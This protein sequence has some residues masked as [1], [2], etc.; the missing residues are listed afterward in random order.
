MSKEYSLETMGERSATSC[1]QWLI[2]IVLL[3][4][5]IATIV[6]AVV[7]LV[8]VNDNNNNK[9]V[10]MS[11]Q[12]TT[13]MTMTTETTTTTTTQGIG[14]GP[15]ATIAPSDTEKLNSYNQS[16]QFFL[17]SVNTSVDACDDFY[18]YACGRYNQP[19]SFNNMDF[20][21][22]RTMA[23]QLQSPMYTS[24]NTATSLQQVTWLFKQCQATLPN[25]SQLVA[26]GSIAL[27]A[28]RRFQAT[29]GL[30]F[31]MLN[32]N[33]VVN[34][35]MNSTT[36]ALALGAGTETLISAFI[37]TNWKQP[38]S[39]MPYQLY[40]D[41]NVLAYSKTYY[42]PN[43]WALT[44]P[45]Y[46]AEITNLLQT[47]ARL[48]NRQL[49][50]N[51]LNDDIN[52]IIALELALARNLSTDDATRR[53][54]LRSYNPYTLQQAQTA[55][56]FVHWPT[57]L[58]Q[59]TAQASPAVQSLVK[60]PNYQLIFN[61]VQQMTNLQIALNDS[62][63]Y[64][65]K[66]RHIVN[67]VN[68]RL[69]RDYGSFLP[70]S[71]FGNRIM[72]RSP[73][74]APRYIRLPEPIDPSSFAERDDA[75]DINCAVTTLDLQYANAR[76]FVDALL[77]TDQ[78]TNIRDKVGQ[79][80]ESILMAFRSMIDQ[81]A[82]MQTSSKQAAYNKINYLVKNI[83]FP[84]F[85]LDD[86]ALDKYYT[87]LN[88]QQNDDFITM[89]NKTSMFDQL[90]GWDYLIAKSGANRQDFNGPPGIVNA[91]Y[92][93]ELNSITFPL[94]ILQQ[95]FF[96]ERWPA[97]VN[98]GAL[99]VVA[100]HELTHGYD[101]EGVQWDGT[102]ALFN[103]MDDTSMQGFKSM[104]QCVID[105]YSNFCP[106]NQSYSPRCINGV[107][108]QGEN[109]AD[110]GG[111]QAAFRAYKTYTALNGPDPQMPNQLIGQ[112]SHDQLFF[113][114]FAQVWCSQ[115][116]SPAA[117]Y[118]QLLVDPHSPYNYRVFGTIQNTAAFRD[119]FNCP[120]N[121][122]SAPQK[123]CDVW[124]SKSPTIDP[125]PTPPPT[126]VVNLPPTVAPNDTITLSSYNR[127]AQ[128]FARTI[129]MRADP[130]KDFFAYACGSYNGGSSFSV[131]GTAN[132]EIQ[133]TQMKNAS[134]NA[135]DTP[136]PLNQ[137]IWLF[138]KCKQAHANFSAITAGGTL[139]R[140][141]LDD[142]QSATGLPFPM[143][144][145]ASAVP[146]IDATMIGNA[147]GYLSGHFSIDTFISYFIDTNW[148]DPNG[149]IPYRLF[150]D[151]NVLVY[152]KTYYNP[153][154]WEL[155][156][157]NYRRDIKQL[158]NHAA[159]VFNYSI[160]QT[161][162][163]A[164]TE[165]ILKLELALARNFSTDDTTRR[166]FERSFNL[167]SVNNATTAFTFIDWSAY[168]KQLVADAP[169]SVQ[170]Q[171]TNDT[172]FQFVVVEVEQI[173]KLASLLDNANPYGIGS[174]DI[175]NYLGYRLLS[176]KSN[177]LPPMANAKL[178][179]VRAHHRPLLGRAHYIRRD[180]PIELFSVDAV[181]PYD[182]Q[183]A[184]VT[185]SQMQYAN[186]RFF[187]D[188][189]YP[190]RD[191]SV[192][193][194]AAAII[195]N[196]VAAFNG[197]LDQLPWMTSAS[198]VGAYGKVSNLIKNI[199][200]PD[201]ILDNSALTAYYSSLQLTSTD[202]YPTMLDKLAAFNRYL[203]FNYFTQSAV[204]RSDFLLPP[205]I[206]N[207]WYQPE[208][209]SIT[210][211]AGILSPPYFDPS[212]PTSVNYGALGVVA[213]HELTHGY[214]DQGV[215]WDGVG[216][217]TQWLDANSTGGFNR[218]ATCVINEYGGFCP[219][220]PTVYTP[221]CIN[222]AQ[223]QGENIADNGG[224]HSAYRAY[225]TY[226]SLNGPDPQLPDPLIGQFNHDQ[227]FFLSFAQVWCQAMPDEEVYRRL[228]VDVHSPAKYRVFGTIQN[229]AAFQSAFNC[230]RGSAYAPNNRCNVWVLDN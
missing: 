37:D 118:R 27:D 71:V 183:C 44:E 198:K 60:Q 65:I 84:D 169:A 132:Y 181:E 110:N 151:Q 106:L 218:M 80:I 15:W 117:I 184:S 95:P 206:V 92:Q 19:I 230:P 31:P 34:A 163:D 229:F 149:T 127:S 135:P 170:T 189:L 196:V 67:Y 112:F 168:M 85:I 193:K 101:D 142:F 188:A 205:G 21:N 157:N 139:V 219:L 29:T 133:A 150:I 69:I 153:G 186:A 171:I 52:G 201:F 119:A 202:D 158:L 185:T 45:T 212:G 203:Q 209:N 79:L 136:L 111:I 192:R 105:E 87:G 160:N 22:F 25:W 4:G 130:C 59:L 6:I 159:S 58:R 173:A 66:P 17:N 215:Q 213:G 140:K 77:P 214:D 72:K 97:S 208:L 61:E 113:L 81:L 40:I 162:L 30:P 11:N 93:P 152:S 7:I 102:G 204:D 177:Y 28:L 141:A 221:N 228:L 166:K 33:E 20:N 64:G 89:L 103:W 122:A 13:T 83:A 222:G 94:G 195:D 180:E 154:A 115:P 1:V 32:Q 207:A 131:L 124:V 78:G 38:G 165:Q 68:F 82:W 114:S 47:L 9:N 144:N 39:D 16:V 109:I 107:Q 62:N 194:A 100:G 104:A 187:V 3:I 145:Q 197:M 164:D 98:Y 90:T 18:A 56:P 75:T 46:R 10:D 210:F 126:V 108:T 129:N 121:T 123:H 35:W 225:R 70:D 23:V 137:T 91:W 200:Y 156:V 96:D 88:I 134:Y 48:T 43:A 172:S 116:R 12:D 55:F 143:L 54:A 2:S 26:N 76:I 224:I 120:V 128:F 41:Q 147:V 63:P 86:A 42:M 14:V 74:R 190:N 226:I 146:T 191:T 174:R 8:K 220:D 36:L 49:D 148:K 179:I 138:N 167:Y 125:A 223:T 73:L 24:S 178:A 51:T 5:I 155:I 227:L 217:L 176:S 182:V 161:Q 211:P 216:K 199:A 99:G 50:A 175:V 57:Y 53:Q